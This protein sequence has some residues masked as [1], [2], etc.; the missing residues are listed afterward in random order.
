[1]TP[2]ANKQPPST[3]A[4][5]QRSNPGVPRRTLKR[6]QRQRLIDA[7]I[8]LCAQRGFPT[9]TVTE[10]CSHAGVS[11]VTFY[12]QFDSKEGCFLA[13]YQAC[14]EQIFGPMRAAA[15]NGD[16]FGATR[17][18]LDTLLE[19]LHEDP[20]AGRILFTEAL[21]A[22]PAVREDRSRVF[23][24][25]EGR[26]EEILERRPAG[27]QTVDVPLTAVIG[28]LRHIIS[29]HLRTQAEDKLPALLEDGLGWLAAYAVPAPAR[30][31][32]TSRAALLEAAAAVSPSSISTPQPLPPGTHGLSAGVVARSQR[33]RLIN[34]LAE[35]MMAKGYQEAK[36]SD[37]VAAA[38]VARPIFY[39]HFPHGKEQAFLEAQDHP[40][41]FILDTCAEA[42]FSVD[43]WPE[44]IWRMLATLIE[45]I[46]SNPAISH[47]RLVE[48]YAAG[49]AAIRR[50]EEITRSFTVFLHEGYR[51]RP[52]AASLPRLCSH[53]IAGAIFEIVQRLAADG[54][55]AQMPRHLPQ[56]AYI[57]VAPFTGAQEA[58]GI[59]EDLKG[60]ESRARRSRSSQERD[61]P[62][63]AG[64]ARLR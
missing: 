51:Y 45:L 46:V 29:R 1:L 41:Q 43:A 48:C 26:I 34:A 8:E 3:R 6:S 18:A 40:T 12:E 37:I 19:G 50:A 27:T 20:D 22:G 25:F 15:M 57:A 38:R 39:A 54:E 11:P 31:W 61:A 59:V 62:A 5:Y 49:P 44:R 47:L 32:S 4:R 23:S 63:Q 16:W 10:L 21:G 28:A 30:P 35:T 17:R 14:A 9:V 36:I 13:A 64:L 58:I 60:R 56:L 55:W 53:A 2:A 33:T 7:M 24:E 42:Y 52:E